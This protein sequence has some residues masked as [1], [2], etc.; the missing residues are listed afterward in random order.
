MMRVASYIYEL[1]ESLALIKRAK[2]VPCIS[3]V[4]GELLVGRCSE[5]TS[6]MVNF[7]SRYT[8]YLT[9]RSE[10]LVI[11]WSVGICMYVG[12]M[13]VCTTITLEL[14]IQ[15]PWNILAC[16]YI[17]LKGKGFVEI[18]EYRNIARFQFWAN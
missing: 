17:S 2:R 6:L 1:W 12:L 9:E 3:R 18:G 16:S 10:V 11:T 8:N 13:D 15:S 14:L 4:L 7:I 5:Y